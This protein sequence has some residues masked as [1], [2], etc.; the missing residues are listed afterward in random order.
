MTLDELNDRLDAMAEAAAGDPQQM[1]GLITINSDLW[2]KDLAD[3]R[4]PCKAIHDGMRYRDVVV[5]VSSGAKTEVLTRTQADG[6][7]EPYREMMPRP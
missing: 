3:M 1:P 5:Q 7:G 2:V 6:R 4:A